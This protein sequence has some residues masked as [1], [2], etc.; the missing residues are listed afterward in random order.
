MKQNKQMPNGVFI[1]IFSI[2]A[3]VSSFVLYIYW[4]IEISSGLEEAVLK[5]GIDPRQVFESQTALV[6]VVLSLLV[7]LILTGLSMSFVYNQKMQQLYRLQNNFINNFTHELKTP[8]TSLKLYL[9]T[10][11]R[12]DLSKEDQQKYIRYMLQDVHRLSENITNILDLGSIESKHFKGTFVEH[13]A[14]SFITSFYEHNAHLFQ[15]GVV[16]V[17][18]PKEGRYNIAL[19][20]PLFEML[21]IN[22]ATNAFKYNESDE[23]S[24]SVRFERN[25]QNIV[26]TFTDNGIGID[27]S[28][29]QKIFKKFYQVGDSNL[30]SAK[31]SGLGLYL[32]QNIVAAHSGKIKARSEGKGRGSTFVVTLPSCKVRERVKNNG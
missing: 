4:Y 2:V 9:E 23:P 11:Q 8:V 22:L 1:F 29:S 6:I 12:H 25:A 26:I 24:L 10:F 3:L 17:E 28:Q 15:T 7:G 19:N 27:R 31:G 16:A 13:D 32:V 21:L 30:M 5:F 18:P 20:A 14:V